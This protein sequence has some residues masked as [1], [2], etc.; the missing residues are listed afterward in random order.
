MNFTTDFGILMKAIHVFYERT[1][2]ANK[3]L[4]LTRESQQVMFFLLYVRQSEKI[5]ISTETSNKKLT[6]NCF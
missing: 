6:E 5:D 1:E 4:F 3:I 2:Q